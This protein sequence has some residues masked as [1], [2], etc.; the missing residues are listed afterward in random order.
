MRT[1]TILIFL[2]QFGH[3]FG[4]N[5]NLDPWTKRIDS[6]RQKNKLT[7]KHYPDKTFVGS[8][9][10]YYFADT[11]VFINTLT[12]AEEAGT[13]T[14]YYI[15]D[16]SLIKVLI[17]AAR[18]DSSSEWTDYYT[19]HNRNLNCQ[20]CHSKPKCE[21]TEIIFSLPISVKHFSKTKQ[22]SISRPDNKVLADD[23]QKTYKDILTLL[24]E[25]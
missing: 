11:L 21:R 6:L 9:T 22:T 8:L 18:F 23:V 17:M 13:E 19:N 4:Q 15:K 2:L 16:G 7:A 5:T 12:D 20:D 24:K 10:G 25:L 1:I 3:C 14:Q